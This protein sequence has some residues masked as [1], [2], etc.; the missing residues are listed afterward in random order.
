MIVCHPIGGTTVSYYNISVLIL[1]IQIEVLLIMYTIAS[2]IDTD[3]PIM[4]INAPIGQDRSNPGASYIDGAAFQAE[5]MELDGMDKK[6]IC[7]HINCVGGNVMEGYNICGAILKSKTPVDTYNVGIAASMAGVIFMCGRKRVMMDYA[8][9]MIHNPFGSDNK[10]QLDAMRDS[11]TTMISAKCNITKEQVAYLCDRESWIGSAE[12]FEKGFCT[13]IEV[14]ATSNQKRMSLAHTGAR[15]MWE[16]ANNIYNNILNNN[17]MDAKATG[18]ALIANYLDLNPEATE[19]SILNELKFRINREVIARGEMEDNLGKMKAALA[20]AEDDFKELKKKY[21][22]ASA[23]YEDSLNV[24]KKEKSE[25]EAKLKQDT[26]D[27]K[28]KIEK[29]EADAKLVTATTMVESFVGKRIKTEAKAEWVE[30]AMALGIDKAKA[31]I[32]G[33]PLNASAPSSIVNAGGPNVDGK[34]SDPNREAASSMRYMAHVQANTK[35]KAV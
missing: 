20:K 33:L 10:K 14:T 6:R 26:A 32:E 16:E 11:L 31:L 24:F 35:R 5:L 7:I 1:C 23:E 25:A 15:A 8:T 2:S 30:T 21:E 27:A 29:A 4:L 3:E 12:C 9:L 18:L 19:G 28:A 34:V 17:T 22:K 13:E